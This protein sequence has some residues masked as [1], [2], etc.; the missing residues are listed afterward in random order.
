MLFARWRWLAACDF[1]V[2]AYFYLVFYVN[3]VLGYGKLHKIGN[4]VCL[5]AGTFS[6]DGYCPTQPFSDV[7]PG[8]CVSDIKLL[9][10]RPAGTVPYRPWPSRSVASVIISCLLL[11]SDNVE[12][13][14][15]LTINVSNMSLCCLNVRSSVYKAALIHDIINDH[16]LDVL[17]LQE[18]WISADSPPPVQADVAPCG[19]SVLHAHRPLVHEGPTREGGLTIIY[20]ESVAAQASLYQSR[21]HHHFSRLRLLL[22][23]RRHI[24]RFSLTS[25]G[26]RH[27]RFPCFLTSW[28]TS[29]RRSVCKH[30]E[31]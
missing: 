23:A 26:H 7:T 9:W 15:G 13:N 1:I 18:M 16:H 8:L 21:L 25:T 3:P 31:N 4:K 29:S 12:R 28:L 14:P 11:T 24:K 17:S 5:N 20:S 19:Y 10:Y 6:T 30:R 2:C 22:S 27:H